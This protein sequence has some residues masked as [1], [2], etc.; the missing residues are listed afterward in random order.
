M[1]YSGTEHMDIKSG[2]REMA[3][4]VYSKV[5]TMAFLRLSSVGWQDISAPYS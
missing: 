2:G 4:V 1:I 5:H 3:T